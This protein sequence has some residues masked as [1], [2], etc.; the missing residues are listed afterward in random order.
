MASIEAMA[1]EGSGGGDGASGS[2]TAGSDTADEGVDEELIS[3][4]N[5]ENPNVWKLIS[6]GGDLEAKGETGEYTALNW[7]SY[8]GHEACV[9]LLINAGASVT[10][11]TSNGFTPLANAAWAGYEGSG[12]EC[13]RLLIATGRCDFEAKSDET[14]VTPLM[15]AA[16]QGH[17]VRMRLLVD[18]GANVQTL[19]GGGKTA[20]DYAQGYGHTACVELLKEAGWVSPW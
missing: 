1:D 9:Q 13:V 2:S 20:M 18:A 7:A 8:C 5:K 17:E 19:A 14:L 11:T 6:S 10:T 12:D 16:E 15:L 3:K 4:A